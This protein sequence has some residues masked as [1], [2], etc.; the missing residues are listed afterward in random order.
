MRLTPPPCSTT[1][2]PTS[3][4]GD[5]GRE[6]SWGKKWIGQRGRAVCYGALT[7]GLGQTCPFFFFLWKSPFQT[8]VYRR[9]LDFV[10][11]EFEGNLQCI[12]TCASGS[13][14]TRNDSVNIKYNAK[15]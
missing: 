1:R 7:S 2:S 9:C 14:Y 13:S 3:S 4:S 5:W 15:A 11:P 12:I 8:L 10:T 6:T